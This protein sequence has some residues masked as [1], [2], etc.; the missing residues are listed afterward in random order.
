MSSLIFFIGPP[1]KHA[2]DSDAAAKFLSEKGEKII[3]GGTT[4]SVIN[5]SCRNIKIEAD[6]STSGDGVPAFG[7]MGEIVVTEG[8]VTLQRLN[9]V[10]FSDYAVNNA[11]NYIK[12][13]LAAAD[14][15][16]IY[17]GS[18]VNSINGINKEKVINEFIKNIT[19]SGITPEI[20]KY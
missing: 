20:V 17:R 14:S 15:I 19:D 13:C 6:L 18:A 5:R 1:L 11:V 7:R 8:T 10:F 12:S 4:A 16:K 9:E 2:S 3:C